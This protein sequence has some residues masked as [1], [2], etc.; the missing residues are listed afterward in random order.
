MITISVVMI[1]KNEEWCLEGCLDSLKGIADEIIVVDTGSTDRTKEIAAKFTD[2]IYDFVWT[3]RF[4]DARNFSF[5]KA[6]MDYIYCADAD[7]LLDEEN[8]EKLRILKEAMMPE[9]EIV[10]MFYTN[11]LEQG[12]VY[13][14][15][16]EYR[17]KLFKRLRE[18]IW[19][20]PIHET[21]RLEPV[22]FDSEIEIIHRPK[23]LHTSRDLGYFERMIAKREP[24]SDRLRKFYVRELF[25]S[26]TAKDFE[27][28]IP[29]FESYCETEHETDDLLEAYCVL[30]KGAYE[31]KE[32]D[33]F[34][35]YA[36]KVVTL[37]GCAEICCLLGQYFYDKMDFTEA[38]VW[39]YNGAYETE[40][41]LNVRYR[42][43][44][45]PEGLAR[46]EEAM[47]G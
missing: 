18:F 30:A 32:T 5:S 43:E 4:C 3:G 44:I 2:K 17:P 12:T 28:A 34:F 7:E 26:G 10:Q 31:Q 47:R 14:F 46:C 25:V 22:V 45:A 11:Q 13:N 36:M 27:T 35:K 42:D 38:A 29:Y 40:C 33:Q 6:S 20:E 23:D 41:I 39:F 21:V 1:V 16:R 37:G 19:I 9:I 24:M 8:Q 15:D